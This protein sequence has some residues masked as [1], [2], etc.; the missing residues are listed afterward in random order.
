MPAKRRPRREKPKAKV[1]APMTRCERRRVVA[2]R[3]M[4]VAG[5]YACRP[6]LDVAAENCETQPT[7][8]VSKDAFGSSGQGKTNVWNASTTREERGRT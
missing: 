4:R 6:S 1:R 3:E 5:T 7:G 2:G 8:A